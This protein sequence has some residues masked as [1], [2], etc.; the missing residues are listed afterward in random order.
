MDIY[1]LLTYVE[2]CKKANKIATFPGLE[3]YKKTWRN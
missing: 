3:E 1:I 2:E